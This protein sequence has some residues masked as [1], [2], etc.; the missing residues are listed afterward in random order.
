MADYN[1]MEKLLADYNCITSP[2][3]NLTP[4]Q[5]EEAYYILKH[6]YRM[7]D[8]VR[9]PFGADRDFE[10]VKFLDVTGTLFETCSGGTSTPPTSS[11]PSPTE[12]CRT[13]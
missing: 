13:K 6:S 5:Q 7:H 2:A 8:V 11:P 12:C 10:I 9:D 4:E 1:D 3:P